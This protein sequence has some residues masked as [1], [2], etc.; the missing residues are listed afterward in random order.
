VGKRHKE[1]HPLKGLIVCP[2][3]GKPVPIVY[4]HRKNFTRDYIKTCVRFDRETGLKT[5]STHIGQSL[6]GVIEYITS[7]LI[8]YKD[9]LVVNADEIVRDLINKEKRDNSFERR[10]LTGLIKEKESLEAIIKKLFIHL[11]NDIITPSDF[12]ERVNIHKKNLETVEA[13]IEQINSDCEGKLSGLTE[14]EIEARVRSVALHASRMITRLPYKNK[15][16]QREILHTFID[17]IVHHRESLK[18]LGTFDIH[19]KDIKDLILREE[20]I[21][22]I[23]QGMTV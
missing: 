9:N 8:K 16:A 6:E 23:A 17:H 15:K 13:E 1:L 18:S 4:K 2:E 19:F 22:G 20:A 3:C 12:K 10:Q 5:C 21:K 7:E 14:W 11:E